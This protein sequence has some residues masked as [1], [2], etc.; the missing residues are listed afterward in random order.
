MYRLYYVA[1]M[2]L[3]VEII[4]VHLL[5]HLCIFSRVGSLKLVIILL[6]ILWF[7]S[8]CLRYGNHIV[9][10]IVVYEVSSKFRKI[11][12]LIL[13]YLSRRFYYRLY[14]ICFNFH[15]IVFTDYKTAYYF[16]LDCLRLTLNK[17]L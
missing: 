15:L 5:D 14:F 9:V 1:E 12:Q 13:L 10:R 11:I 8:S 6:T 2:I 17:V 16:I 7:N 3:A 4:V